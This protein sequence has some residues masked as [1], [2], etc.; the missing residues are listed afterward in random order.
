MK[1]G[2]PN[3]NEQVICMLKC[4]H[5]SGLSWIDIHL[6]RCRWNIILGLYGVD[7]LPALYGVDILLG[8]YGVDILLALYGIDTLLSLR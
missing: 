1:L 3:K 2:L 4:M 7:I 6:C 8:L 5:N